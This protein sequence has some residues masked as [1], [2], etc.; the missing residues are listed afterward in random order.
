M[1]DLNSGTSDNVLKVDIALSDKSNSSLEITIDILVTNIYGNTCM[2]L[3]CKLYK[4]FDL[5]LSHNPVVNPDGVLTPLL[6]RHDYS[7]IDNNDITK[8]EPLQV[9]INHV[10]FLC[11]LVSYVYIQKN[12]YP[13]TDILVYFMHLNVFSI[14]PIV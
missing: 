14:F 10:F 9:I 11:L 13:S 8:E 6:F 4:C 5:Y 7:L 3:F 12:I 2:E 1:H